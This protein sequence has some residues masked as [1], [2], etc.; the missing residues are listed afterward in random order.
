MQVKAISIDTGYFENLPFEMDAIE[1][2][3]FSD[4]ELSILESGAVGDGITD[5]TQA[6][7]NA[8]KSVS[9]QGGGSVIIP[10]GIWFTGPVTLLSNVNLHTQ[11]NALIIFDPDPGRYPIIETSFEGLNTRRCTSPINALQAENIAITG[12][13][14]FDGSGEYWTFVKKSKVTA[15]HWSQLL[16]SAGVLNDAEDTWFPSRESL[17]GYLISEGFNNPVGLETDEQWEAVRHWLRPVFVSLRQCRNVWID[18]VTFRN[19]PCWTLHP[20]S[21]ENVIISDVRIFNPEYFQNS[22]AMDPES[23]NR[24][25]IAGCLMN[26]GDDGMCIKSGKDADGRERG[27]PCQY[28]VIRNNTVLNAHG[29]FVVGSEMSGGVNHIYVADCLF[30]GTDIG[31]RFKSA[32]GRGGVVEDIWIENINMTDMATDVVTI[33]LA[34]TG[35]SPTETVYSP[36]QPL[37]GEIPEVT[38]E[39]PEFR[40]IHINNIT[41]RNAVRAMY[42][43]GL[44]ELRINNVEL[45]EVIITSQTGA[46]LVHADDVNMTDV[47]LVVDQGPRFRLTNSDRITINGVTYEQT[48]DEPLEID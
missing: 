23:C 30:A 33:D 47:R 37:D 7:N 3:R 5:N 26:V 29:G 2:P 24:V 35:S 40:R 48:L 22:D 43:N 38:E 6:I 18:E 14:V 32:R 25:L 39:T 44:P 21:C 11:E 4:L 10:A 16:A 31:L 1:T 17:D 19:S 8:I 28:V 36:V 12:K 42:F 27:E 13:G 34:Y 20:L 15:S 45:T 41:C 46:E 9:E